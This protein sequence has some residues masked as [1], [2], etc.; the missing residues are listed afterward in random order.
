MPA[1]TRAALLNVNH[2]LT[3]FRT[4]LADPLLRVAFICILLM[5]PAIASV[6]PF[7]SVIGIERLS[8]A[9]VTYAVMITLGSLFSVAASIIVGII[10]DQTGEYRGVLL[11][12][13]VV[14]FCAGLMMYLAPGIP[15]F[16]LVHMV[17]FPIAATT[18]TQYFALASIAARRNPALDKNVSLALVRAGF[19]GSFAITPP[20]WALA[21]ARDVDLLSIY[22]VLA[23]V[24]LIILIVVFRLWPKEPLQDK[25]DKSGLTFRDALGELTAKPVLFRLGLISVITSANGLYNILLGLLILN[26]LGGSESDVGWFAGGVAFVELPVMLAS[27]ALLARFNRVTIILVGSLIFSISLSLL[28]LMPS[29]VAAWAL[30]L[31]FGIGAGIILSVPVGYVQDLVAHRPGAGSS[32][33]SMSHFGGTMIASGIFAAG[34]YQVGYTGVAIIGAGLGVIA[35]LALYAIDTP[36]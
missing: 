23:V 16:V 5:G 35:G 32:L 31:P 1:D 12:C 17:L 13:I 7:Q 29:M 27:A 15:I 34:S 3:Q 10:T 22:G 2:M 21:L 19:A 25:D 36:K 28:G 14:G 8:M 9:P 11:S 6:T 24:N 4:A 26:T 33:L 30:I 20:I 18:F